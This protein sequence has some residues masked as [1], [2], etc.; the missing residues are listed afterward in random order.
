MGVGQS[1]GPPGLI[2]APKCGIPG[3]SNGEGFITRFSFSGS[4]SSLGVSWVS[5]RLSIL[6]PPFFL[7][8]LFNRP[9]VGDVETEVADA[10][11]GLLFLR[12]LKASMC[13]GIWGADGCKMGLCCKGKCL[14]GNIGGRIGGGGGGGATTGWEVAMILFKF[15]RADNSSSRVSLSMFPNLNLFR[16]KE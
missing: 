6:N 9:E 10:A 4:G 15:E 14:G 11:E 13:G 7:R 2:P 5:I 1:P 16:L 12:A 3:N 8:G